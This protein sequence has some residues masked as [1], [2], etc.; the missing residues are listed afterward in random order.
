MV[1]PVQHELIE[2]AER[3]YATQL[4][5]QLEPTHDGE[6]V[7][8]EPVSGVVDWFGESRAIEVIASRGRIPLLGVGRLLGHRL[9][10]D[11]DQLTLSIE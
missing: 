10:V 6:F 5:S 7:A 11:Y 9:V 8:I 2:A 3:L 1:S 4:R